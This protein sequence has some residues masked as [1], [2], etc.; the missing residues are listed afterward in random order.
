MSARRLLRIIRRWL[1][2]IVIAVLLVGGVRT[3]FGLVTGLEYHRDTESL[4]GAD[5]A[6]DG[7]GDSS[8][9]NIALFGVDADNGGTRRSDCMMVLSLDS[10][11]GEVK[12]TSL[13][14]DSKVEIDGHGED[15]LNHSYSYGGPALAIRTINQNFD[16]DIE[17]F[18][19]VDFSQMANLIGALGGVEIDVK[20]KE[21]PELNKFIGEYCRAAGAPECPVERPGRQM[22]NGIQAMSYGRIRKGGTGDDWGRVERQ[23]VVLEAMF[24]RVR[25]LS[26]PELVKLAPKMLKYVTSD[27]SLG[28]I[29][30][31]GAGMLKHGMPEITHGRIPADGA[32]NYGG[33]QG[34]YI[35]FDL[36]QAAEQLHAYIYDSV[37]LS[38]Q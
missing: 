27:L 11:R 33:S 20:E 5:L 18:V 22:L 24:A 38:G 8:V 25:G 17:H 1:T 29:A 23:G 4:R 31:L 36:E 3:V 26:M 14:R 6:A 9:T 34:Q 37:P 19:Q 32:W 15:K 21:I 28:E 13:M 35:V 12:L 30:R 2:L 16:L 10:G 7:P